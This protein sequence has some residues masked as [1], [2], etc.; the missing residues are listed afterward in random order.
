MDT[1]A[2]L[3]CFP[4][5]LR[6]QIGCFR[7]FTQFT[8]SGKLSEIKVSD[9][10]CGNRRANREV[11]SYVADR[12]INLK[13]RDLWILYSNRAHKLIFLQFQRH[14]MRKLSVMW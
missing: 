6:I 3:V 10:L 1:G 13:G 7:S 9:G 11:G 5:R 4:K 14:E 8:G 12:P 2:R